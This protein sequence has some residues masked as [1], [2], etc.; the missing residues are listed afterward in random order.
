MS[1]RTEIERTLDGF[2]ADG[3][4][5]VGDPALLRALDAVDR[6]KQRR[7]VLA[8]WRLSLMS[9]NPRLAA[10]MLV[11]ALAVGGGAY[12][13]GKQSA[14]GNSSPTPTTVPAVVTP[15]PSAAAAASIPAPT[16]EPSHAVSTFGWVPFTSSSYG[17]TVSHP[18]AWTERPG[19]G[20][21]TLANQDEAAIDVF[22]SP[23]GW[24]DFMGYEAQVPTGTTSD[25][26]IAA[27]TVGAVSDAC[28]PPPSM[29][30]PITVDGHPATVGYGGCNEHFYFAEAS[31]VI[32]NRVWFFDLHGP[33][34]SLIVP[35]LS[36][37][38]IDPTAI[39]D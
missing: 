15:A 2:L 21:W 39:V 14:V 25:A 7:D 22:W 36:T 23:S 9:I 26:F 4:D 1:S 32:G 6:T 3:P 29:W 30:L 28:M 20:H 27:Y 17:F 12:L 13:V 34:R 33:D 10:V 35:F 31:V 18:G 19:L 16:A 37:V 38:K 24:P 8:P 11:A 5:R